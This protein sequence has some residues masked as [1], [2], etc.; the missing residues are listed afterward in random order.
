MAISAITTTLIIYA[1]VIR[2]AT[3]YRE[4]QEAGYI[5]VFILIVINFIISNIPMPWEQI[6]ITPLMICGYL[7]L[8]FIYRSATET[9]VYP[10]LET[11]DKVL[12]LIV[13]ATM[14]HGGICIVYMLKL[15]ALNRFNLYLPLEDGVV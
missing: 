6:F 7:V 2:D 8:L 13:V 11:I 5:I 15:S 4:S 12:L 10:L 3:T 9:I 1:S 14:I